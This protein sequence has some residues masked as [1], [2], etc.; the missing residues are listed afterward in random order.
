MVGFGS[1]R[2][3]QTVILDMN[4][5]SDSSAFEKTRRHEKGRQRAGDTSGPRVPDGGRCPVR[6]H[7]Q[8]SREKDLLQTLCTVA[9]HSRCAYQRYDVTG[10]AA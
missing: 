10:I 3:S 8:Y 2:T 5:E 7:L 6:S 4:G 9:S 1:R